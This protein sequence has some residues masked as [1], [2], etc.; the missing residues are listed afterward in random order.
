MNEE[1][2]LS[3]YDREEKDFEA[4]K[5]AGYY[6]APAEKESMDETARKSGM[7]YTAS[8]SLAVSVILGLGI[9][10]A[11]DYFL[12]TSPWGI[13]VGITLGAALGFY[14]FFSITSRIFKK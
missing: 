10:A 1:E 5:K 6:L 7:A 2:P 11:A 3:E 8:L 13:L 12:R 14:L 9:G 4:D